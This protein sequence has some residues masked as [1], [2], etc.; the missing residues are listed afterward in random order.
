MAYRRQKGI[1]SNVVYSML[2]TGITY[3]FPLIVYPYISRVLGVA[4]IG[5]VGF[6]DSLVT[7]FIL[8]SM[9]GISVLGIREVA[10]RQS[11][12]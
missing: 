3:L 1:R 7:Y 9:M 4:N 2:L 5:L 6:I 12:S 8:I 10:R 11:R